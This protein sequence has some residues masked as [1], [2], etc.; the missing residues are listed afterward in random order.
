MAT[1]IELPNE[2]RV[3]LPMYLLMALGAFTV[4][5][6][7]VAVLMAIMT[8]APVP[9]VRFTDTMGRP[10]RFGADGMPIMPGAKTDAARA[11]GTRPSASPSASPA[12]AAA[13]E[14]HDHG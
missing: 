11:E 13:S 1:T 5:Y 14:D 8:P 6:L 2:A 9:M 3:T 10:I 7:I 4:S 12:P